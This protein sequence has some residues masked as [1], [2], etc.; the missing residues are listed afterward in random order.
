MTNDDQR[1]LNE[2]IGETTTTSQVTHDTRSLESLESGEIRGGF[3][4]RRLGTLRA[5]NGTATIC[6]K[7]KPGVRIRMSKRKQGQKVPFDEDHPLPEI[8][9]SHDRLSDLST[10]EEDCQV[11][12]ESIRSGTI[13]SYSFKKIFRDCRLCLKINSSMDSNRQIRR[14]ILQRQEALYLLSCTFYHDFMNLRMNNIV[15]MSI[16]ILVFFQLST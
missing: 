15:W 2:N 7:N 11:K 16:F 5:Q 13:L 9:V 6:E 14:A 8:D 12:E 3:D 1:C 4:S 10:Q